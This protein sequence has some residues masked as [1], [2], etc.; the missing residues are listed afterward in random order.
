M[1]QCSCYFVATLACRWGLDFFKYWAIAAT[2]DRISKLSRSVLPS[3]SH[4]LSRK[5]TSRRFLHQCTHSRIS[6]SLRFSHHRRHFTLG[7]TIFTDESRLIKDPESL[8]VQATSAQKTGPYLNQMTSSIHFD[9]FGS[10]A[11]FR[12]NYTSR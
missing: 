11:F 7:V 4:G 5:K 6:I 9:K 10:N 8:T 2:S 1:E 3:R 12:P